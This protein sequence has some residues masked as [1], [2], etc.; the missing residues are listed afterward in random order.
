MVQKTALL[1]NLDAQLKRNADAAQ[2]KKRVAIIM[3]GYSTERH[4]SVESGRNIYEKLASSGKYQPIPVFLIGNNDAHELYVIPINV[5]LKDNADDIKA[6]VEAYHHA[7]IISKI[8][9]EAS[10]V[11][12]KY[13]FGSPI[14][15][16]HRIQYS[17]L[18]GLCESVFIALHGRPGE[19]GQIQIELDKLGLPYN[20][21]G[22]ESSAMTIDK[23]KTNNVLRDKGF[24]S[25]KWSTGYQR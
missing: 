19:D 5:M 14:F 12:E 18:P 13:T 2:S 16:P 4:I 7:P 22:Y 23:F 6:K 25:R 1:H 10:S 8:I 11:T 21:S 9:E 17:E 15:E 20:G 3:G 24:F